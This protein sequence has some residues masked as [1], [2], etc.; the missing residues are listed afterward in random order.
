MKT[1]DNTRKAMGDKPIILIV[2]ASNPMVFTDIESKV[3]GILV[4]FGVQNSAIVDVVKG[5]YEPSGLLPL[6]MPVDMKTVEEQF[7]DVPNDMTPYVDSNGNVYD[8]A[9]GLNWSGKISDHRTKKY[10]H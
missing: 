10:G 2:S 6:Q 4:E 7:E 5:T 9:F 3:D 1:I 8:F